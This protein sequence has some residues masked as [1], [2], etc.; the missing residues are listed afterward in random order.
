M[1]ALYLYFLRLVFRSTAKALDPSIEETEALVEEFKLLD[2][3][4]FGPDDS[5]STV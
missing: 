4:A 1:Y 5:T 2:P 3:N